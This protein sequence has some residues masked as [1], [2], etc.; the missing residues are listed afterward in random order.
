MDQISIIAAAGLRARM[1]SLDMLANNI[2]NTSTGGYKG[3]G[4]F[5]TLFTSEAA[6]EDGSDPST[7]PKIERLWTDFSQGS[8]EPTNN[9]LD[10][11]LSGKGFF[12]VEG[13]SGPLYTRNGNFQV[14]STGVIATIDGYPLTQ[15]GGQSFKADPNKPLDVSLDGNIRQGGQL[16]GQ[17]NL[18]DFQDP[19]ILVKQG[20]SYFRPTNNQ[21]PTEATNVQVHQGKIEASNVNASQAAVRLVSVM[22][23]FEMMQKAVS[24]SGDMTKKAI[25]EVA[26]VS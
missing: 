26:R 15:R 10:M 19:S 9:P 11:G 18:V 24:I 8:L 21:T 1:E 13:P 4:E 6:K 17:V 16:L 12:T 5:Y 2:A 22:R 3:D 25:E 23:Q 20:N 7:L 14:T